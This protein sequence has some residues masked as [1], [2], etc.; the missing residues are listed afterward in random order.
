MSGGV[1]RASGVWVPE[2]VRGCGGNHVEG[3]ELTMGMGD[4]GTD[5]G[6]AILENQDVVDIGPSAESG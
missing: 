4:G 5:L 6:A 1:E 3:I 2:L